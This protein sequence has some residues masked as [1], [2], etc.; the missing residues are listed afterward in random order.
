MPPAPTLVAPVPVS[1]RPSGPTDSLPLRYVRR[2]QVCSGSRSRWRRRFAH[3]S[4]PGPPPVS[5]SG[6]LGTRQQTAPVSASA[7]S[8]GS[9]RRRCRGA[10]VQ[11]PADA[12]VRAAVQFDQPAIIG[13]DPDLPQAFPTPT[14]AERD[15]GQVQTLAPWRRVPFVRIHGLPLNLGR[16]S[17]RVLR[18]AALPCRT[19][20][21]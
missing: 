10:D 2:S 21:C 17:G 9:C 18:F 11:H 19:L 4:P 15:V 14:V 13:F 1:P 12:G 5:R 20:P 6:L 3:C 7:P 8:S 16:A